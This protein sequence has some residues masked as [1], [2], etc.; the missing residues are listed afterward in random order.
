MEETERRD[1]GFYGV[2]E[3]QCLDKGCCYQ[4]TKDPVNPQQYPWCFYKRQASMTLV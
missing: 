1:C 2:T 3:Q 4:E